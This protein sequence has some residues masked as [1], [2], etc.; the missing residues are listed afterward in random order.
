MTA[1]YTRPDWVRRFNLLGEAAGGPDRLIPLAADE[2]MESAQAVT[3]LA[4]FGDDPWQPALEKLV[5]GLNREARLNALGRTLCRAEILRML[6]MR[7]E[8]VDRWRQRPEI[9]QQPVEAPLVIAGPARSGTTILFELLAQDPQLRAPMAWE[10][11]YP[12][13]GSGDEAERRRRSE[14]EEEFWADI[15]PE[16]MAM[17]EL[18]SKLP[19]ECLHFMAAEFS[20]EFWSMVADMPEQTNWRLENNRHLEV[21]RWH[22]KFLQTLQADS[23]PRRWLLKT[24]AHLAY[25][26]TLFETYPDA[27]VIHTHRDPLKCIPSTASITATVRWMRSD[28]VDLPMLAQFVAFGFQF[29][30]E[31]V[32]DQRTDGT[33]PADQ[34]AD[35]HFRDLMR[36][37]VA[38]IRKIYQQLNLPFDETQMPERITRYLNDKPQGKFGR[39][40][41]SPEDIGLSASAG[42]TLT[43]ASRE[44]VF[45]QPAERLSTHGSGVGGSATAPGKACCDEPFQFGDQL[46]QV[47]VARTGAGQV[48]GERGVGKTVQ[49]GFQGKTVAQ[50]QAL[51]GH[52]RQGAL[53]GLDQLADRQTELI[54]QREARGLPLLGVDPGYYP[55]IVPPPLGVRQQ[56]TSQRIDHE[57]G[58]FVDAG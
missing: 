53:Q 18:S 43:G 52:F 9:L 27:R 33:L 26:P 32:I 36:D 38:A 5:D 39:H 42:L 34:I 7:L 37:P 13:A 11:H 49:H 56:D 20:A 54:D 2:L 45:P 55:H 41:Y 12:L 25:L 24:P 46:F 47:L 6:V 17:H 14:C 35:L 31:A 10:A 21:Y 3:G 28:H 23:P 48:T 4:D 29:S 51:F 44:A 19:V 8:L 22:K 1:L 16:F 58:D 15:Q 40:R 30:M 57:L 50:L